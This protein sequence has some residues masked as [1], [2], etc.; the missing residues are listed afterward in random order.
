[1]DS[2]DIV[3]GVAY[4]V[5]LVVAEKYRYMFSVG[6]G[7]NR[8]FTASNSLRKTKEAVK[9]RGMSMAFITRNDNHEFVLSCR[10]G[11]QVLSPDLPYCPRG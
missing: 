7:D 11:R 6:N 8:K 10:G 5:P 3:D 2:Y 1:M 4:D 9:A